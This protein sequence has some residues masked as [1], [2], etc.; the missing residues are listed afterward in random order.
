MSS[1][2]LKRAG[3]FIVFVLAQAM[4]L[5]HIHLFNCA[6]PLFYV[7]FVT[8]FPRNYPKWGILLWGFFMG[9][10][11]DIFFNTPGLASA[12]LTLIAA[13]Q[14]YYFGLFVPHDSV[15]NLQPSLSAIGTVKYSYYIIALVLLYCLVFY[16]LEIFS[17]RGFGGVLLA[18]ICSTL[19][20]AVLIVIYQALFIR[21]KEES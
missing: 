9:L 21:R 14:P 1:D 7:Y 17:F 19:A 15:D 12:S 10:F 2:L 5:G 6:T 8:M 16:T 4:V 11:I 18:T 3:L 20:T 13:V